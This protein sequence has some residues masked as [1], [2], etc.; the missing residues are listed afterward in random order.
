M[1]KQFKKWTDLQ[2]FHEVR[3]NLNYPR[4]WACLKEN[5]FNITFGFKVKLHGTN[6]AV[7]IEPDGKV[8]AQKRSSDVSV[9]HFGFANWV[10][11]NEAYF[12]NLANSSNT[13]YVYGEWAG[14]GV[15][16]GVAC[17]ATEEKNFYPF[18][19]D[20]VN[21]HEEVE[22]I[23]D[24]ILIE[25]MLSERDYI[26]D[27][28]IVIPWFTKIAIDFEDANETKASIEKL[29]KMVEDIGDVDPLI[30]E[31]FD[32][33]GTGEGLVAYPLLGKTNGKYAADEEYFSWF[34]FKAKSEKHRVNNTKTA[35]AFDPAKFAGIQAFAD[36]FCTEARFQQGLQ[37]GVA[38]QL[39][40]RRTGDFIKWVVSDI[41]KESK[42]EREAN[43]ELDWKACSKACS[44]R[45]VMWY[46]SKVEAI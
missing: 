19:I 23:Y 14:P 38:E 6:A 3:K 34:N 37:E 12:A 35:V 10:E 39:D 43:E 28:I 16:N 32:I 40:M 20:M 2:Q 17:S 5:D 22:R 11:A 8:V 45:A 41:F 29:N 13:V 24:P 15:Q 27:D 30:E 18:A 9:G 4:I 33:Q 42:T 7:R 44:S 25:D 21:E 1:K 36:A 31:L 26:P 46:K